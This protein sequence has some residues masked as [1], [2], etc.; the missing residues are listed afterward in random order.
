MMHLLL[1]AIKV[2][3]C[4]VLLEFLK[5]QQLN[6]LCNVHSIDVNTY[7]KYRCVS[8]WGLVIHFHSL[9]RQSIERYDLVLG[10]PPAKQVCPWCPPGLRLGSDVSGRFRSK[11]T[12]WS[13]VE[14]LKSFRFLNGTALRANRSSTS[15]NLFHICFNHHRH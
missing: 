1:H 11:Q 10:I 7:N 6:V 15:I 2:L 14:R 9:H 3:W 8:Q 4:E 12:H 13:G 5:S